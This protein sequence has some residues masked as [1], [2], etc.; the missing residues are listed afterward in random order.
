MLAAA[1]QFVQLQKMTVVHWTASPRAGTVA[2]AALSRSG[3]SRSLLQRRWSIMRL[4]ARSPPSLTRRAAMASALAMGSAIYSPK[5][6]AQGAKAL[7]LAE[8]VHNLGYAPVY[9]AIDQGLFKKRGLDVSL[10]VAT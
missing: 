8:P 10:V 7:V 9:L 5:V 2:T 6:F 1:L 3:C 4:D